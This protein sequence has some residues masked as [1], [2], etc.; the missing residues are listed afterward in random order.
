MFNVNG[1]TARGVIVSRDVVASETSKPAHRN[2][3][4]RDTLARLCDAHECQPPS[5][6]N[7]IH[8]DDF[9]H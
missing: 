5:S 6:G 4:T 8:D 2:K 7:T 1:N 3:C 9:G